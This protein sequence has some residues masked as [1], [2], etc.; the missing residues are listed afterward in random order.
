MQNLKLREENKMKRFFF[1]AALLFA[2]AASAQQMPYFPIDNYAPTSGAHTVSAPFGMVTPTNILTPV[3]I[4]QTAQIDF[5]AGTRLHLNN[6]F[7]A[8]SF[9]GNGYFHGQIGTAS[10]FEVVFMTPNQNTPIVGQ[11]EKLEIGMNLPSAVEQ[12]VNDFLANSTGGL[13]PFD[14]DQ[15]SVEALFTNGIESYTVYGFYYD[16]FIRDPN[17]MAPFVPANW[18]PQPT[19]YHWRIRFAPPRLGNWFCSI[20]IRLLNATTFSYAVNNLFFQCVPSGNK[21]WLK[22]GN[23]NWHLEYSRSG[24][25]FFAL[26]QNIG[27]NDTVI[28]NGGYQYTQTNYPISKSGYLDVLNWVANLAD[29]G[30][31]MVRFSNLPASFE[32]EKDHLNNYSDRLNRAWELDKMFELCEQKGMKISF[33]F[34]DKKFQGGNDPDF[35]WANNPYHTQLPNVSYPDD[36]FT[37][38]DAKK[39]FKKKMRYFFSRWGYSTSL[40]I[41][42]LMS[43]INLN[44]EEYRDNGADMNTEHYSWQ[45][46]MITYAKSLTNFRPLL[47]TSSY[48][49]GYPPRDFDPCVFDICDITSLHWY[50][51]ERK[52]NIERFQ[53]FNRSVPFV[54]GTHVLWPDK[55]T[56]FQEMGVEHVSGDN[57][58]TGDMDNCSDVSY[59]NAL[60]A[61][62]FMG[63]FGTGFQWWAWHN[64]SYRQQNYP[65]LGAFFNDID[66]HNFKFKYPD[67]WD[68]AIAQRH[69]TIE[70]FYIRDEHGRRVMGWVHNSTYWWGNIIQNCY[71]RYNNLPDPA[72]DDDDPSS[73][74]T[75]PLATRF[76]VHGLNNL[77]NY[78]LEWFETRNNGGLF[79]TEVWQTNIGGTMKPIYQ[80]SDPFYYA[81]DW[82]FKAYRAFNN[83]RQSNEITTDTL[84]CWQDTFVANG[85]HALDSL[86]N[87]RYHWNFGNGQQSDER[88]TMT[89]YKQSGAYLVTLIVSDSLGWSDTLKQYI[90]KPEPCIASRITAPSDENVFSWNAF[91]NPVS[92]ALSLKFDSTWAPTVL[93]ELYSVD[94][95]CIIRQ[96]HSRDKKEPLPVNNLP[97]GYYILKVT[98]EIRSDSK[99]IIIIH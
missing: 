69:S 80:G 54:K 77:E 62:A 70:T 66:F 83:F 3:N 20:S 6:G 31:N 5:I 90:V 51:S 99:Q 19:D 11:F 14:P 61:T 41:F 38:P 1:F 17:A 82:A 63:G 68:D 79:Q 10:D 57:Y 26:G 72:A 85:N 18:I 15:I 75:L 37:D 24:D 74:Q 34:Q 4:S 32:L 40:G 9:S 64:N 67:F 95:K 94:G 16:E 65:A 60:W 42:A 52:V 49:N 21:G 59:H 48:G 76:E 56:Y 86:K 12:Q 27:Y 89:I 28:F 84:L 2:S 91:P 39:I 97:A 88:N 22:K 30:G 23:D 96:S 36:F 53:E 93:I 55:P 47:T 44:K 33:S 8:G 7:S 46:D 58:D 43:E 50:K 13:N 81:P 71:D 35:N 73:P 45:L 29:N 78:N 87:F 98:D 92:S 25:S